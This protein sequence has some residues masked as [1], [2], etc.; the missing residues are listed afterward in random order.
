M[1]NI[2]WASFVHILIPVQVGCNCK[3]YIFKM[4]LFLFQYNHDSAFESCVAYYFVPDNH[5][6]AIRREPRKCQTQT[7]TAM[8]DHMPNQCCS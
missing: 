4:N 3:G 5:S 6:R 1:C 8:L 2:R 7:Q